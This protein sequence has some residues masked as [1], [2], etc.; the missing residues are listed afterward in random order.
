MRFSGNAP[1]YLALFNADRKN[2]TLNFTTNNT[3]ATLVSQALSLTYPY[4]YK[5]MV[6]NMTN[7]AAYQMTPD[8]NMMFLYLGT[9]T[10]GGNVDAMISWTNPKPPK[11]VIVTPVNPPAPKSAIY[12]VY[13][14]IAVGIFAMLSFIF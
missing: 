5:R 14:S 2:L 6:S 12:N 9:I 3:N 4:N 1:C 7:N 11:E 13:V 8:A 10:Q